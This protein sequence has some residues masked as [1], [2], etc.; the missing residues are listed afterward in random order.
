M[1]ENLFLDEAL[2]DLDKLEEEFSN[3]VQNRIKSDPD[4]MLDMNKVIT[5]FST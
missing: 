4:N 1:H 5:M 2:I 3:S